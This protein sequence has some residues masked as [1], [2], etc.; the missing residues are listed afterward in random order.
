[1][2]VKSNTSVSN[3]IQPHKMLN[4]KVYKKKAFLK[5]IMNGNCDY[6]D[7]DLKLRVQL[8]RNVCC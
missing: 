7:I 4:R 8:S 2:Y 5:K 1:M 3:D 6:Y